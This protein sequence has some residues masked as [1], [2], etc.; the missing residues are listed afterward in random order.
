MLTAYQ[1]ACDSP[2]L[3]YRFWSPPRSQRDGSLLFG[4]TRCAV[5]PRRYH[6][7]QK[8]GW[9]NAYWS[10]TPEGP[11]PGAVG[12]GVYLAGLEPYEPT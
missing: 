11:M 9:K 10:M 12:P 4:A 1:H 5:C 8:A 2:D 6:L 7:V 3:T